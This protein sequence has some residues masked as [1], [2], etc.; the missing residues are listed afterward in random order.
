MPKTLLTVPPALS[1]FLQAGGTQKLTWL[2]R[3]RDPPGEPLFIC[4]DPA[5][6]RLGSGGGTVNVL[7]RAWQESGETITLDDWLSSNQ[8]LVLHAG[9]ESR[10]LPAYAAVGKAFLPLP[11]ID[12]LR[13]QTPDQLLADFQLPA[14]RQ[15]LVEA[16][17][18]AKALVTSGDVWLDFDA[19]DI[20]EMKSDIVGVG[21][22]VSPE[23]AQHF[24][25]YFVRKDVRNG[26]IEERPISF[27]RQKPTVTEILRE[28]ATYDFFV[29]TGMWLLSANALQVL[30]HRCGWSSRSGK[31][32]TKTGL[33]DFL[34]LY[35]EVGTALGDAGRVPK[36]LKEA[37]FD[38][39][40]SGVI[41]LTQARFYHLGSSRQLLE[42]MEQLQRESPTPQRAF[43]IASVEPSERPRE[44]GMNWVEGSLI[45][46]A[47]ELEGTNLVTGLPAKAKLRRLAS[48]QCL[49]VAPIGENEF[50]VR[51]YQIDDTLRGAV[52]Q[53]TICGRRASD[54][55]ALRGW[56]MEKGD[57]FNIRI[58]PV[59]PET[60]ITDELL[61][62]FF[63][64]TPSVALSRELKKAQRLSAAEIPNAT[65]FE[66]YFSQRKIGYAGTLRAE[67]ERLVQHGRSSIY[68]Q[69]FAALSRFC[70]QDAP[71]LGRWIRNQAP[72][73]LKATH[74]PEHQARF[75]TFLAEI[76]AGRA[77]QTWA[78]AGFERLQTALVS[79]HQL[80]KASPRLAVKEDQIVW[81]RSPV[82]LDLA[83]GWTDTPPFCLEAGGMCPQRRRVAERPA[84]DSGF[85]SP[86]ASS[87]SSAS[88]RL[89]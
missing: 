6:M 39:L 84:P 79:T 37:G 23:V 10:R 86:H 22:Q 26:G 58:Y 43:R 11:A 54:W 24:G 18:K 63:S 71:E 15:A 42:S 76:S 14:Y 50:V 1:K 46:H 52:P 55:F 13:P 69:D 16:G 28:I 64:S 47:L 20:P 51:P 49:D 70:R 27:F 45:S 56:P 87:R 17:K 88:G 80:A 35:T 29:D 77:K 61:E 12:G 38:V 19:T 8:T 2:D 48:E 59:L 41:P 78:K 4:T 73:I 65:N 81:G 85:C 32:T 67:F 25:V 3:L 74:R 21:M 5:G 9:G 53:A 83:G 34:D 72:A 7:H 44:R 60:S 30:F 89:I 31:F 66:R 68:D 62:W 82:R 75:L 57:V 36:V 33:P 40:T